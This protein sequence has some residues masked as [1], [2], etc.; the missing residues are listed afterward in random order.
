MSLVEMQSS[1]SL[2][3][4]NNYDI[5]SGIVNIPSYSAFQGKIIDY[6]FFNSSFI[7]LAIECKVL[8]KRKN[9]IFFYTTSLRKNI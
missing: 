3:M 1:Q 7:L 4:L 8:I 9:H 6:D 2:L 5:S